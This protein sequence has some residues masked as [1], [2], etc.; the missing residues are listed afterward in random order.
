[1]GVLMLKTFMNN[2]PLRLII[3]FQNVNKRTELCHKYEPDET[4]RTV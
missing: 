3:F 1:M 2:A 4:I